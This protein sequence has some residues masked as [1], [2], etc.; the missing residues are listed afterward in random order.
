MRCP[1]LYLRGTCILPRVL[2]RALVVSTSLSLPSPLFFSPCSLLD[3]FP[4]SILGVSILPSL[5]AIRSLQY[6]LCDVPSWSQSRSQSLSRTPHVMSLSHSSST[7]YPEAQTPPQLFP[8]LSRHL[9]PTDAPFG[10]VRI[11]TRQ[12]LPHLVC[13]MVSF[14]LVGSACTILPLA[15]FMYVSIPTIATPPLGISTVQC[16]YTL[17]PLFRCF[18]LSL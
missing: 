8:P 12:L 3:L 2:P 1:A 18:S 6:R 11:F 5:F 9:S 14:D 17:C 16:S 10:L 15:P 7:L 13:H 4:L